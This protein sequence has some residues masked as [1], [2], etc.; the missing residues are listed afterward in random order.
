MS[1]TS[2]EDFAES[3]PW[4]S[5]LA[6]RWSSTCKAGGEGGIPMRMSDANALGAIKAREVF[7]NKA[8]NP[9]GRD[10]LPRLGSAP[11]VLP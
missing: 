4:L 10:P 11:R 7:V 3:H 2:T 5:S 9:H 8:V 1:E 6:I